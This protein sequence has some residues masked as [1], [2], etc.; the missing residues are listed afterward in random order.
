MPAHL[1]DLKAD[2]RAFYHI[3]DIHELSTIEFL[4]LAYRVGAYGGVISSR[5]LEAKD[6]P[7]DYGSI[8][9]LPASMEELR[10]LGL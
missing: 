5:M 10:A 7:H 1:D 3:S 6:N 2:F 8:N 4:R 9:E